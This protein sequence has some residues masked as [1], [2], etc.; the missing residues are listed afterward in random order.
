MIGIVLLRNNKFSRFFGH[1]NEINNIQQYSRRD[2]VEISGIPEEP[3]ENTNALT[4]LAYLAFKLM[5]RI[6]ELQS[7]KLHRVQN[8]IYSSRL[9]KVL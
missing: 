3:D 1:D 8:E 4:I 9:R 2:C 6:F 5:M 7:P